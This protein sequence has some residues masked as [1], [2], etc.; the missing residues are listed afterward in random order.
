M[1]KLFDIVKLKADDPVT[2]VPKD[3]KGAVVYIHADG[4][5]YTVEFVDKDG[6]TYEG[7]FKREFTEAEL[8]PIE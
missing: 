5:A 1:L 3:A 2:G 6:D 7:S 4:A 8:L